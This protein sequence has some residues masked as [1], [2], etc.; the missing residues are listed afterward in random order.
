MENSNRRGSLVI[1]LALVALG[2][3]FL[4][5]QFFRF[6]FW[7]TAWPL[8]IVAGGGL[9]LAA[10]ALGG[11]GAAGMFVPGS[12]VT[13]VGL[14][15]FV[16]N[17]TGRWEAWAYAWTLILA[18]VGV[19]L[20]L[21]GLRTGDR[22]A[23]RRGPQTIATGLVLLLVFGAFFEGLIFGGVDLPRWAAPALLILAG[24]FLLLRSALAGRSA[25]PE[26]PAPPAGDGGPPP[27]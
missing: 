12:I 20:W 17:L 13:M 23:R 25:P 3:L 6:N 9:L 14:I 24:L 4:L 11:R 1:G 8:F 2:T 27:P 18:A 21:L 7:D 22:E 15:T 26:R 10:A 16:L 19:G 5:Q